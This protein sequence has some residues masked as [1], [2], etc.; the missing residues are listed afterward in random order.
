MV[1]AALGC[2]GG[3]VLGNLLAAPLLGKAANVYGVGSLGVPARV[4][5][6]VAAAMVCLVAI[7]AVVPAVRA[8]RFSAAQAISVGRAP[9]PGRGYAAHRLLGRLPL[10]RPVTIGLAGPFARPSRTAVTLAAVLLGA[11]AVT[12]TVGLGGS[13]SRML[14]GLSLAKTV[15]VQVVQLAQPG[16]ERVGRGLAVG[17]GEDAGQSGPQEPTGAPQPMDAAAQRTVAAALRAQPGT[18]HYVAEAGWP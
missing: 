1:P 15:Q 17:V 7:V 14:Y 11:S 12:L 2:L 3:L 8:G 18:L 16:G 9:R 10:P 13:L 6:A 5:V 4:D